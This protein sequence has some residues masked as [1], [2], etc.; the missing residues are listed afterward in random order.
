MIDMSLTPELHLSS[1][2][3]QCANSQIADIMLRV[4][5]W[6]KDEDGWVNIGYML[7]VFVI[8][9]FSTFF[10]RVASELVGLSTCSKQKSS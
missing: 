4:G 1:F 8:S 2:F 5:S 3:H 7:I 6:E 9:Q 10:G